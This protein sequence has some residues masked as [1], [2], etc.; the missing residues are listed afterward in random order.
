MASSESEVASSSISEVAEEIQECLPGQ[1]CGESSSS[2]EISASLPGGEGV[3]VEE[4]TE[5]ISSSSS[6][7]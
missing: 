3:T 6:S 7:N 5:N 1:A 4:G 2:S